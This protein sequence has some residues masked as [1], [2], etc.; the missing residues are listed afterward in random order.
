[1]REKEVELKVREEEREGEE[2]ERLRLGVRMR[3]R[4]EWKLVAGGEERRGGASER[5]GLKHENKLWACQMNK[6]HQTPHSR[7]PVPVAVQLNLYQV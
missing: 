4:E 5:V 3:G 2:G 6:R 7:L 1:M